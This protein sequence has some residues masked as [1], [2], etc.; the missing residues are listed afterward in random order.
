M[1]MPGQQPATMRHRKP[2]TTLS[3]QCGAALLLAMLTVTLVATAS[4]AALMGQ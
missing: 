4:F 1:N 3:A 2:G